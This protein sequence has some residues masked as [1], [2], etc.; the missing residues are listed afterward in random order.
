MTEMLTNK[1]DLPYQS[2]TWYRGNGVNKDFLVTFSGGLPLD[3][4]HVK[5]FI[6]DNALTTGWSVVNLNGQDYVRFDSPPALRTSGEAP[7]IMLKRDTPGTADDRAIDFASGSLLR[8][9]DLDK[10]M[11]NA[12]YVS[13]ESSDLFL[14]QGGSAVNT[15]FDQEIGGQK[16]FTNNVIFGVNSGAQFIP[17]TPLDKVAYGKQVVLAASTVD[18]QVS[19]QPTTVSSENLPAN[20]VKTDAPETT[21]VIT[22]PKKFTGT[23]EIS[24]LKIPGS[25]NNNKA[26]VVSDNAGSMT[27]SPIVNGIRLGS[28]NASVSTGTITISPESIGALSANTA[29]GATQ[30]VTVPVNF[31]NSIGLGDDANADTLTINSSLIIKSDTAAAGKVLMCSDTA[32]NASWAAPPKTG[33]ISVNGMTG[34]DTGGAIT[35]TAANVQAVSIGTTQDIDGAKT[36]TNNVTLGVDQSDIITINGEFRIPGSSQ[37]QV[38]TAT[39]TGKVIWA[40]PEPAGVTSVNGEAGPVIITADKLGAYTAT[41]I[42]TASTTQAGIMKVG[43]GLSVSG[44]VVNVNQNATLPIA[45][46]TTLGGVKVGSGLSI[47][48]EGVMSA[49]LNGSVGVNK[50]GPTGN[51]RVGDVVP[52]SGDYTAAMVTNAVSTD[53]NQTITGSKKFSANQ[54]ISSSSSTVGTNGSSGVLLDS[55]GIV[56]AQASAANTHVFEA[57]SPTGGTVAWIDSDGDAYFSGLV[58]AHTGFLSPGGLTVGDNP[59]DGI[60]LTGTLKI[61]GSANP[62][63]GLVLTCMN[64]TG[65]AQWQSPSNAPVTDVNGLTGNVK[66]SLDG[67][68]SPSGNLGGVTKSTTQTIT[69]TK[70]FTVPQVFTSDVT[71][72]DNIADNINV[73]GKM[74]I[75]QAAG[76]TKVLT[77]VDGTGQAV[78]APSKVNSVRGSTVALA[79]AQTGDVSISAADVGAPTVAQL[80]TVA[81]D[82]VTA[83]GIADQAKTTADQALSTANS[84]I[85]AVTTGTTVDGTNI[86]TCLS[87]NGTSGSPLRVVGAQPLGTAGGVLNGTYPNPGLVDKAVGFAKIQDVGAG[88]IVVGPTTGTAAGPMTTVTVGSGL[89]I[90]GGSLVNSNQPDAKLGTANTWTA[91]NTFNGNV[92]FGSTSAVTVNNTFAANGNTTLG[93]ASTDAVT[94]NGKL[95]ITSGT[96][97]SGKVLTSDASG[98]ATWSAVTTSFTPSITDV[99]TTHCVLI[100]KAFNNTTAPTVTAQTGTVFSGVA[101][102]GINIKSSVGTWVGMV[103]YTSNSG[104]ISPAPDFFTG[105]TVNTSGCSPN[106]PGT[107][108]WGTG[109]TVT[110]Q[111]ILTRVS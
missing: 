109:Y 52:A 43:S 13:Q 51:Q 90:T 24:N 79:N 91:T 81:A 10:A 88:T 49:T 3:R 76:A 53:T 71:L 14:D 64:N 61:A 34:A 35:L 80:N 11:L 38:L 77:C 41:T 111:Y 78:W 100:S 55:S 72:G 39:P 33:I 44:G 57:I 73:V 62:T 107:G 8:S 98:N 46:A 102:S 29:G 65:L 31:T 47:N 50:F 56:K 19:W 103:F 92:S 87:G 67:E 23:V 30:T 22:A 37:G 25:G 69:G 32:G 60:N 17:G 45:S 9:E 27:L 89:S 36:F 96:P 1:W 106:V 2:R 85:A 58:T 59:A 93:D 16:T 66:I 42:P 40:T 15:T 101:A 70:T 18:G 48:G 54:S 63:A 4:S 21:Q 20:V 108:G 95:Q 12:L 82:V 5:V 104:N 68:T 75:P 7:N 97:G 6:N 94:V 110:A 28:S 105:V 86:Y 26:L 99:G 84:K 74:L 83:R